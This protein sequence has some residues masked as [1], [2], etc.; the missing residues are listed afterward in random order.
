MAPR[1][2][3]SSTLSNR[4][5]F[6][7]LGLAGLLAAACKSSTTGPAQC[8]VQSIAISGLPATL[9]ALQQVQL[10]ATIQGTNCAGETVT[11]SVTGGLSI[12]A[13]GQV[14][15]THLGGPFTVTATARGVQGTATTTV[16]VA[17]LVAD[18]RWA[19]AWAN[20][21]A[22]ADYAVS[23]LYAFSTG[24][25]IRSTRSGAGT[26]A[27][28]FPGLASGA[29]QRLAVHV[30]SYGPTPRRCRVLS[31]AN[32]GAELVV[33]V[34]CHDFAGALADSRFDILVVPAG[35]TGGRSA[36]VVSPA[37]ATDPID[38]T[39]AHNSTQQGIQITR[40]ATG[41]Y[42]VLLRGQA[43]TNFATQRESFHVT[44]Y[45]DG[46]NWCKIMWWDPPLAGSPDLQ[47]NVDCYNAAG[48]AAD[49]RF[50]VLML[51]SGRTGRRLGYVWA[52]EPS[53]ANYTPSASWAFN[54][55]A[56]TN[57]AVRFSPGVYD[58]VWTGLGRI[59]GSTAETNLVTS[60]GDGNNAWCQ[61]SNWGNDDTVVV[62]FNPAG[63][64]ADSRYTAIWI[65]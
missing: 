32:E 61:V 24:G 54:S 8:Q 41:R 22:S 18:P 14:T 65:E 10:T 15:G 34:R 21:Q 17:A 6:F 57:T 28:R 4:L 25:A 33:Q 12:T 47:L 38:A 30:S 64:P 13:S 9:A 35:S 37:V 45:G 1:F 43:R 53:A 40:T 58:V 42:E 23:P 46:S 39:T 2:L 27:V 20:D 7:A 51:E 11:W 3:S 49:G 26:Y 31:W 56:A 44:A 48:A 52:N 29:G 59:A 19:L 16:T 5:P 62:C 36:F 50:A 55:G 60:Y 63:A